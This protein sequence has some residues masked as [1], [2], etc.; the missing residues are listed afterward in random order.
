MNVR[1]IIAY[2]IVLGVVLTPAMTV[3]GFVT[4]LT[5]HTCAACNQPITTD[6]FV[7]AADKYYHPEHFVC[8]HCRKQISSARYFEDKGHIYD[9]ACHVELFA[10][11]CAKCGKPIAAE[12]VEVGRDLY[13]ESCYLQDVALRC[14]YCEEIIE[15]PYVVDYWGNSIHKSHKGQVHQCEYCGRYISQ[16]LSRGSTVYADGR[17]VCGYCSESLVSSYDEAVDLM[18]EV[19]RFLEEEGIKIREKHLRLYPIDRIQMSRLSPPRGENIQAFTYFQQEKRLYGLLSRKDF[20][21][22]ILDR[23]PKIE[24]VATI[25]HELMHVWLGQHANFEMHPVLA[26]G[27][28]N[29]AAFLVLLRY[30]DP[31]K[32]VIDKMITDDDPVYGS[33]FQKTALFAEQVGRK[34]WLAYL[35]TH[36]SPPW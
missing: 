22:Y 25:A 8:S 29:Y 4:E 12:Y 17:E 35:K 33:G 2:I 26:E 31:A 34:E 30:G 13:H 36:S 7:Q 10:P 23:L 1:S 21:I 11:R 9:S 15:G 24:F 19:R 3:D 27:S 14:D 6:A 28:C 5:P 16:K 18:R 32:Y 20:K